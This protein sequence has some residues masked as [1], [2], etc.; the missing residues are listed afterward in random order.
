MSITTRIPKKHKLIA[1]LI[2]K[3]KLRWIV[4]QV[5]TNLLKRFSVLYED[6]FL[7]VRPYFASLLVTLAMLNLNQSYN[8]K[9]MLCSKNTNNIKICKIVVTICY[10]INN[11]YEKITRFWL[12][13][14]SA[15]EE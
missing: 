7:R 15:V 9:R 12:A 11:I 1:I 4:E 2:R 10:L 5:Y 3:Y 13:E 8:V 14:S 6:V